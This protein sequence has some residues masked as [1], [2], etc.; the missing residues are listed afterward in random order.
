[1][2]NENLA[3]A[4]AAA[5]VNLGDQSFNTELQ[6]ARK[7]SF[8]IKFTN[9]TANDVDIVICKSYFPDDGANIATDGTVGGVAIVSAKPGVT[10]EQFVQHT[11]EFATRV[12][13]TLISSNNG[14]VQ[15]STSIT[16]QKKNSL[17][18][19]QT[20][21][22]IDLSHYVDPKNPN[23]RV[24]HVTRA[25]QFDRNH[26]VTLTIPKRIAENNPTITTFTFNCGAT[27]NTDEGLEKI[28]A[29]SGAASTL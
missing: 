17:E 1:M 4:M 18:G 27:M 2:A 11:R 7:R 15:F 22:T 5:P 20:P 26:Q 23:E 3:L 9:N 8:G 13:L 16:I 10:V 24:L 12:P 25:M 29:I 6:L 14:D 28:A 21:E 19:N